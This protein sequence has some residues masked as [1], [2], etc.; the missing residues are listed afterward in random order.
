MGLFEFVAVSSLRAAQL[1]RG[2]SPRVARSHTTART[3][4]FEVSEG[5]VTPLANADPPALPV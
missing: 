5:K 3:A 1:M 2:C 4:Q